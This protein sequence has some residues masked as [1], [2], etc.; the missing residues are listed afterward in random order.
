MRTIKLISLLVLLFHFSFGQKTELLNAWENANKAY[1]N[2]QYEQAISLYEDMLEKGNQDAVIYYNLGNAYYKQG[3][4]AQSSINY[5]RALRMNPNLKAAK[6]NF[7][8]V[9]S[10]IASG[11]NLNQE[12]F[13]SKWYHSILHL[14]SPNAWAWLA[15]GLL[16]ALLAAFMLRK[17]WNIKYFNRWFALGCTLIL[18][19]FSLSLIT[20]NIF[21]MRNTAVVVTDNVFLYDRNQR[22]KVM[23]RLPA[24]TVLQ[25]EGDTSN[26]HQRDVTLSN[27]IKGWIDPADLEK[28]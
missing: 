2:H 8:L 24:G 22:E 13:L 10:Q 5:L 14:M 25:L 26:V 17:R 9:Q 3:E 7:R 1:N 4:K 16:L 20:W 19:S 27:G 15:S 6:E 21:R 12:F 18:L 23:L 28:I 11:E